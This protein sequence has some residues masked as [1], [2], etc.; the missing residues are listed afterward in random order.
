MKPLQ[1][2]LAVEGGNVQYKE[3]EMKYFGN[4]DWD[5]EIQQWVERDVRRW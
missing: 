2:L 3:T 4:I 1:D 5:K